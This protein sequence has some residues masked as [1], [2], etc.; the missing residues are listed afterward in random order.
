MN[1]ILKEKRKRKFFD[2]LGKVLA[3]SFIIIVAL[4]IIIPYVQLILNSLKGP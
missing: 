4:M 1:D 3:Y 2:I